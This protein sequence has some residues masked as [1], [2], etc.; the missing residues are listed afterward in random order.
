MFFWCYEALL[1][2]L[3]CKSCSLSLSHTSTTHTRLGRSNTLSDAFFSPP[4]S[5]VLC[6]RSVNWSRWTGET[7][8]QISAAVQNSRSPSFVRRDGILRFFLSPTHLSYVR[9][10][11]RVWRAGCWEQL[12]RSSSP[13]FVDSTPV[14]QCVCVCVCGAVLLLQQQQQQLREPARLRSSRGSRVDLLQ[15]SAWT[16]FLVQYTGTTRHD[17]TFSPTLSRRVNTALRRGAARSGPDT[18]E[19]GKMHWNQ[20][21][22]LYGQRSVPTIHARVMS[23]SAGRLGPWASR[24]VGL[25]AR[26]AG[27]VRAPVLSLYSRRV[28]ATDLWVNLYFIRSIPFRYLLNPVIYSLCSV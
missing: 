17:A 27:A 16:M 14:S 15:S 21:R 5:V 12:R 22:E 3:V 6:S 23:R 13:Q 19:G 8:P 24:I 25:T 18:G 4:R 9:V 7:A 10:W 20:R 2:L 11:V 28:L 1:P 26:Q